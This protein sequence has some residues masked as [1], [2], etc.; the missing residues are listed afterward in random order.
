MKEFFCQ[1][2]FDRTGLKKAATRKVDGTYL[3]EACFHGKSIYRHET[4]SVDPRERQSY[5]RERNR[6]KTAVRE[7]EKKNREA[8]EWA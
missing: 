3:C 6:V 5:F 4:H 8:I 7:R 2:H 1:P